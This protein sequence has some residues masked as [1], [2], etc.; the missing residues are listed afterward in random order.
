LQCVLQDS[1]RLEDL[2]SRML[3]LARYEM[4]GGAA[5]S[6]TRL[7]A[8]AD[9]IVDVLHPYAESRKVRVVLTHEV[10]PQVRLTAEAAQTLISNL[11]MNAIQHSLEGREVRINVAK[12]GGREAILLVEDTGGG[13][14]PENLPHVFDRFYREDTSRPRDT[15]GAGLGLSI[16]KSIVESAG[17]T[18]GIE[19]ESGHGTRI[20]VHLAAV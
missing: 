16:C 14:A 4:N 12:N 3:S 17:G 15:G 2:I 7:S 18:I 8:Q 19:S 11:L 10:D 20:T 13:I 1:E 9:F 6:E 5:T